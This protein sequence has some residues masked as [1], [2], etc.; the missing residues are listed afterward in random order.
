MSN[1]A[2]SMKPEQGAADVPWFDLPDQAYSQRAGALSNRT[3]LAEAA[4]EYR[5]KGYLIRDFRFSEEDLAE[6]AAYTRA[7]TAVRIQDGWL[8]NGAIK[9][10]ATSKRVTEFLS[11]LYQREAFAFQTL[12]FPRGSQQDTHSDTYHFNSIPGGFMCGVWIALE[13]IHPDSGPLQYYPGSHRR[14]PVFSNAD[15]SRGDEVA[16]VDHVAAAVQETGIA[17]ETALIRR[18]QAF[19]WASNLF[20]GGSPIADAARTRLSQVTHYYFRGCSYFT[21]LASVEGKTFWREPYD[22]AAARF[23]ANADP[24][25]RPR[26]KYRLGERLKIW[27]K[28]PHSA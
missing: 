23:V 7:I 16:Y 22:I 25:H 3:D 18:G 26:L 12:N 27:T 17:R 8:V 11:E 10:L 21:P 2:D 28:T 24:S 19:I 20:H 1:V 15:L 4:A 13:D 14:L 6:A 9:R 5:E